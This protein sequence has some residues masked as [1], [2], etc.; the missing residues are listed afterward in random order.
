MRGRNNLDLAV[1]YRG[2]RNIDKQHSHLSILRQ[3]DL[4]WSVNFE[5]TF[6]CHFLQIAVAQPVAKALGSY[7]RVIG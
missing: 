6:S 4:S 1:V 7:E 2:M 3:Y 5:T